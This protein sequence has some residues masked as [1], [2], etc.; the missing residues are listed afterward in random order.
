VEKA[1]RHAWFAPV[2]D[3]V[4]K[5]AVRYQSDGSWDNLRAP[6]VT[7]PPFIPDL[8]NAEDHKHF[9]DFSNP[10]ETA[11]AM[12]KDVYEKEE[13][14]QAECNTGHDGGDAIERRR[15]DLKIKASFVGFEFN[16]SAQV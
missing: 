6:G 16:A 10:N 3:A 13:R 4:K 11:M 1:R 7:E 15:R 9:D 8:A 5:H 14:L 2:N 12:Y